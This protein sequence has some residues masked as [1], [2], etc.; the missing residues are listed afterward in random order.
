MLSSHSECIH[1]SG[2]PQ[3]GQF[4]RCCEFV[5]NSQFFEGLLGSEYLF[6]G[7][8]GVQFALQVLPSSSLAEQLVLLRDVGRVEDLQCFYVLWQGGLLVDDSLELLVLLFNSG[9]PVPVLPQQLFGLLLDALGEPGDF[10]VLDYYLFVEIGPQL[11]LAL[12][13]FVPE[14]FHLVLEQ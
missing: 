3:K 2:L 11:I 12:V 1:W 7:V 5:D 8:L 6:D 14:F 4:G 10:L 13:V 9:D